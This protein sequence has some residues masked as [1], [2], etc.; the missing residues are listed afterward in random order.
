VGRVDG[1]FVGWEVGVSVCMLGELSA[2]ND[3][4]DPVGETLGNLEGIID[5][6]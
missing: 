2:R 3:L 1:E 5:G 6:I 4:G